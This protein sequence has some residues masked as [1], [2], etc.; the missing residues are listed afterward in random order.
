MIGYY[1]HHHGQ[2]HLM[3]ARCIA[4]QLQ[5]EVTGLSSLAAPAGWPG[6]WIEL[7][8]DGVEAEGAVEPS[9]QGALHW[10][11]LRHA[12]LRRRMAQL[13]EWIEIADPD[14]LV[15]DVSVEV[16]G[17]ARLMGVPVITVAMPGTREDDPHTLGYRL[18][19]AILAPW[20]GFVSDATWLDRWRAKTHAVGAF[21]RFDGYERTLGSGAGDVPARARDGRARASEGRA[22]AG[23]GLTKTGDSRAK[24]G[25]GRGRAGDGRTVTVMLGAGGAEIT[26]DD[27]RQAASSTPGWMWNVLGAEGSW[28]E[29]PWQT[30]CASDVVV[31]HAGQNCIAEVAAARRPAI[32]IPQSRPYGEQLA[33][34]RILQRERLAVVNPDWPQRDA[35]STLLET[36]LGLGGERWSRWSSGEGASRA[37]RVIEGVARDAHPQRSQTRN[38]R[39]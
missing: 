36:A 31:T 19:S 12:G 32:V 34:A 5:E 10:A 17:Y 37:A 20:P 26:A 2:G 30:L 29:N 13:A 28:V 25:D 15:C 38:A 39:T 6:E 8:W 3:R 16:A 1:I 18:S 14:A 22:E 21:S 9:A 11:P 35:W 24:P 7:D 27:V 4:E 23:G 33:T